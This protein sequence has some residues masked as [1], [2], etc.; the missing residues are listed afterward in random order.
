MVV[1]YWCLVG[2]VGEC[3]YAVRFE[4]SYYY[5]GNSRL[6]NKLNS[7]AVGV[8]VFTA[9]KTKLDLPPIFNGTPKNITSRLFSKT[10]YADLVGIT[11]KG[12]KVK[13]AVP[14]LEKDALTW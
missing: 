1:W 7:Q 6:L 5:L 14:R 10:Q 9:K 11:T 8:N 2:L 13:L 3:Q 12:N 4:C